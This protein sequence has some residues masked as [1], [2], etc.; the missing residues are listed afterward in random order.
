MKQFFQVKDRTLGDEWTDWAGSVENGQ[1]DS[2]TGKRLFIGVLLIALMLFGAF[3]YVIWYMIQPRLEQFLPGLPL[4]I[5]LLLLAFWLLIAL[6]FGLM[7]LS[8]ISGKDFLLRIGRWEISITF[9]IPIAL[10]FG[11][12]LGISRDRM[13][14]S[15]VK[16]SNLLIKLK[17]KRIKPEKILILLPRCLQKEYITA[18]KEKAETFGIPV[19]VV[20]GGSKARAVIYE[21]RPDAVIGVACERDL[22]SGISDIRDTIPVIAIPNKRPQGPCKNTTVELGEFENALRA[23]NVIR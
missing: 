9:L 1:T 16:V 11:S 21:N 18:I 6:W 10:K 14:N 12:R 3:L 20:S 7:V 4:Y 17:L 2:T 13:G 5:G 8:I 22:L 19:F 23:L 15:L